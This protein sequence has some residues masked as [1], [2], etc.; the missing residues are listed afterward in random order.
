MTHFRTE[1]V[2]KDTILAADDQLAGGPDSDR[3]AGA[4]W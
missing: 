4:V 2:C 1:P 3:A